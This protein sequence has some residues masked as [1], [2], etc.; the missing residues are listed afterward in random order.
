MSL[1]DLKYLIYNLK[2]NVP[3]FMSTL[4]I[5]YSLPKTQP[6]LSSSSKSRLRTSAK[7]LYSNISEFP[8]VS[9]F[10]LDDKNIDEQ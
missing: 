5:H 7:I 3:A 9:E 6:T 2:I 10:S 8:Q 1:I 4:K